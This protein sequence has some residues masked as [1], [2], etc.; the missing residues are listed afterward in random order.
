MSTYGKEG[1][2]SEEDQE[3]ARGMGTAVLLPRHAGDHGTRSRR[4]VAAPLDRLSADF[5]P[6]A[7]TAGGSMLSMSVRAFA[8]SLKKQTEEAGRASPAEECLVRAPQA[9]WP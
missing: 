2:G 9:G 1:T 8:S 4:Q 7:T 6:S 5:E 3:D